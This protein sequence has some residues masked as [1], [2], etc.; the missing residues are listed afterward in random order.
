MDRRLA[1]TIEI[2]NPELQALI[3]D[4]MRSGGFRNIEDALMQALK[5]QPCVPDENSN[6]NVPHALTGTALVA[7]MQASPYKQIDLEPERN[8]LPVRNIEI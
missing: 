6:P 4:R 3:L 1:M 5:S 8:R 2:Q 7:A